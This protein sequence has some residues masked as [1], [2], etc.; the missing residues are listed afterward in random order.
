MFDRC[1][2]CR[3]P[4]E[5]VTTD[6]VT[7]IKLLSFLLLVENVNQRPVAVPRPDP[8]ALAGLFGFA[9][10]LVVLFFVAHAVY[11]VSRS[12]CLYR[13]KSNT[14]GVQPFTSGRFRFTRVYV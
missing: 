2:H 14:F 12:S 6:G 13:R 1:P 4:F 3:R 11:F 7:G 10:A 8:V 9:L 5:S